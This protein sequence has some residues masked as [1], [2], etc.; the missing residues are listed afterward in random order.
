MGA[1]WPGEPGR[2]AHAAPPGAGPASVPPIVRGEAARPSGRFAALGSP[3]PAPPPAWPA[4]PG[5]DR[6]VRPA[7][8]T[9]EHPLPV[10]SAGAWPALVGSRDTAAPA[11]STGHLRAVSPLPGEGDDLGGYR[12]L[13]TIGRGSMGRVF[14]A[15]DPLGRDVAVKVVLTEQADAEGLRRFAREGQ[16]MAAVPRHP[17]VVTVHSTGSF[18][19]QPYLVLDLVEGESLADVIKRGPLPVAQAAA[20][21]RDLA[22]ALQHV[23]RAGVLHRDLK[24]ANILI[25][26]ED[27]RPVITDFGMAGLRGAER[28]TRT[29]DL[30]GTPLYMPPEQVL[31]LVRRVDGRSDVW[32]LG[33]IL[34]EMLAGAPPFTGQ[35]LVDVS[36]AITSAE[37]PPLAGVDPGLRGVIRRALAKRQEDRFPTPGALAD[38]LDAWAAGRAPPPPPPRARRLP[39]ALGLCALGA[40]ALALAALASVR[41]EAAPAPAPEVVQGD[42]GPVDAGS[43]ARLT[44]RTFEPLLGH[45]RAGRML[46]AVGWLNQRRD[47]LRRAEVGGAAAAAEADVRAAISGLA[48]PLQHDALAAALTIVRRLRDLASAPPAPDAAADAVVA[49]LRE[50]FVAMQGPGALDPEPDVRLLELLA[51][52]GLTPVDPVPPERLLDEAMVVFYLHPGRLG[53]RQ[54][55]RVLLA[56]TRL[57]VDVLRDHVIR[58]PLL[59]DDLSRSAAGEFLAL[60]IRWE[61]Q[62]AV[63]EQQRLAVGLIALMAGPRA[64][65]LGPVARGRGAWQASRLTPDAE[66]AHEL[67]DR[68]VA[69]DPRS[70]YPHHARAG[71]LADAGR[72]DEAVASAREVVARLARD[73]YERRPSAVYEA[74]SML[75]GAFN[76]VLRTGEVAE[77]RR[78]LI[79]YEALDK[80]EKLDEMRD[81]LRAAE[82]RPSPGR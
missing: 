77:A 31:G 46:E 50:R 57:D 68:A 10:P 34:H 74:A 44:A 42:D 6:L 40:L 56:A 64:A 79:R 30:V 33:A 8:A 47:H 36:R 20:M 55:H 23:H 13:G 69:L 9:G 26:R 60:R 7:R 29:G 11:P 17:N 63:E 27:G 22:R 52:S 12:I 81:A 38:A 39:L 59:G 70:P 80:P 2:D 3:G 73:D 14:R 28:L 54:Y 41:R 24:P 16:A 67:L 43:V 37:P 65:E 61:K 21:T 48:R 78:L 1:P 5:G 62:A 49:A 66:K 71:L 45:V 18:R 19:G 72:L 82:A 35:T 75:R 25:D 58:A 76:L 53:P 32:A 4:G 15:R 51:D